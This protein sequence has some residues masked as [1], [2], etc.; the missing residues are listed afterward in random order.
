MAFHGS[1]EHFEELGRLR[2]PQIGAPLDQAVEFVRTAM[3][4]Y[5]YC[6]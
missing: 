5:P 3:S 1:G 6:P 4:I 2:F